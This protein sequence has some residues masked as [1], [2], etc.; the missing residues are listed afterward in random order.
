M[1]KTQCKGYADSEQIPVDILII[2]FGY[3]VIPLLRELEERGQ[4]YTLV[5]EGLPIWQQLASKKRL[6][7]DLVSSFHGSIY[8][9]DQVEADVADD[10][11]PTS[12]EFYEYQEILFSRYRHR[13]VED[14]V[15]LVENHEDHSLVHTARG[16]CY[17][18]GNVVFATGLT[19][20]QNETIKNLDLREIHDKTVVFGS[21]G[22]T[23]NMMMARAIAQGNKVILVSNGFVALDKF[24]AFDMPGPKDSNWY[25]PI[26]GIRTGKRYPLDLAQAECHMVE[27][28]FRRTYKAFF[29][30]A[31]G[32]PGPDTILGRLMPHVLHVKYPAT[33]RADAARE[34]KLAPAGI[35][36]GLVVIKY[37]PIDTYETLFGDDLEDEL[38]SGKILNDIAFFH[39]EGLVESWPKAHTTIDRDNQTIVHGDQRLSYDVLIEGGAEVP[40]LPPIV[41]V[42]A[43][44]S[45]HNYQYVY[46]DNYLGVVPSSLDN[47]FFIGYTRPTSAGIA[48][49]TEMQGLMVH[50]LLSDS[51]F[52]AQMYENLD[53]RIEKYNDYYYPKYGP[54]K[55]T[56]HLVYFGFYTQEV[57]KFLGIDRKLRSC[58]SWNPL[59]TWRDIQFELLQPNNSLKYRRQGEYAIEGAEPLS[60]RIFEANDR[61][62]IMFFVFLSCFWDQL[63]GLQAIWMMFKEFALDGLLDQGI[64]AMTWAQAPHVGAWLVLCSVLTWGFVKNYNVLHVLTWSTAMPLLGPKVHLQ[65]LVM[66]YIAFAGGWWHC[67]AL[68]AVMIVL[69]AGFRKF[70]KPPVSGRYIFSDCKYKHEYRP[71]WRRYLEA[72]RK[73]N[74][75][76]LRERDT[77]AKDMSEASQ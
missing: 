72:Y 5:S 39:E 24:M 49:M 11:Y 35:P 32:P 19:R 41:S 53:E 27:T 17:V 63:L 31:V 59:K 10:Y 9:P 60:R 29:S 1:L 46:R 58:L 52:K 2:G 70:H 36:N 3:S 55:K 47:V 30:I 37:W 23:T 74:A 33:Y 4:T 15:T 22:D 75:E 57:A 62:Q 12:R 28:Y 50:K 67:L 25:I 6:D 61:W 14:T 45:R 13:I 71:F 38:R 34:G 40:R 54:H 76:Y 18:A 16:R 20:P 51:D 8:A 64:T 44:G 65:P 7:F 66:L 73:V 42:R 48:N 68:F 69:V 56:D 21:A 43:D 77:D 26:L